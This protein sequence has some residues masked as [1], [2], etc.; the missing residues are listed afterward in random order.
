[1]IELLD[2]IGILDLKKEDNMEEE[3]VVDKLEM[4]L[5]LMKILEEEN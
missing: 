2:V 5:E 4:N 3:K 1:M